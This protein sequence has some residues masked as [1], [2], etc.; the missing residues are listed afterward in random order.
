MTRP[1]SVQTS[2]SMFNQKATAGPRATRAGSQP[3][4]SDRPMQSGELHEPALQ[5][6][7]P[8]RRL[9]V[10]LAG[11]ARRM[12]APRSRRRAAAGLAVA[13]AK[14]EV[15]LE[16]VHH[17]DAP[18]PAEGRVRLL[19]EQPLDLVSHRRRLPLRVLRP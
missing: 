12:R 8:A 7:T 1:T 11:G 10:I 6:A 4:V 3:L 17:V 16:D 2:T 19:R 5:D 13:L 15:H 18:Q 9:T 14:L